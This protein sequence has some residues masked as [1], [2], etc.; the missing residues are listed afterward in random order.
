MLLS[1]GVNEA[2]APLPA[3]LPGLPVLAA[4]S[5]GDGGAVGQMRWTLGWSR[6]PRNKFLEYKAAGHGTDMFAVEKGLEPA[7]STG[8]TP[9][10][11]NAPA[12]TPDRPRAQAVA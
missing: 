9:H 8:S 11:R 4:A 5:H 1:G 12:T 7:S 2:G 10:L 6:N 3:R